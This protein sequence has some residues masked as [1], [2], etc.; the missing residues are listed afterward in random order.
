[1]LRKDYLV[2]QLEEFGKVLALILS[3][4]KENEWDKFEQEIT[5]AAQKY[6]SLGIAAIEQFNDADFK[7]D[8]LNHATLTQ[9][10]KKILAT[11]LFEKLS[12]YLEVNDE[13]NYQALKSKC[14]QLYTHLQDNF[15]ANEFDMDV[16]Y[17]LGFLSK[18]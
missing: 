12:F 17:K 1:M 6:T 14:I 3:L 16:H 15:T 2:R 5:K 18:M 7:K 4:K 10:Q 13:K 8:I 9:E 11:L